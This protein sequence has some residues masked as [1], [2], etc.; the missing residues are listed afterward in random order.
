VSDSLGALPWLWLSAAVVALDQATKHL[1]ERFLSLHEPVSVL[2]FVNLTLTYNPGAAF[3][4][5]GGAGGWQRWVLSA[6]ALGVSVFIVI[7]LRSLP[8]DGTW[9][10]CALALIL[11]GALGN[12]WDRVVLGA[13][14]DF[15]DV[16]YAGWHWPAFNVADSA[17]S[18]GALML[19]ASVLRGE[20]APSERA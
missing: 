8:R 18:I 20:R 3:S 12:L 13:V 7:W 19:L 1:A 14:V 16:H 2:P 17:I 9:L 4:F 5:L 10:P 6:L 15:I 11:G